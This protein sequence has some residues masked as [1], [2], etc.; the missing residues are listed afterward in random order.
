MNRSAK[1]RNINNSA[2]IMKE[3]YDFSQALK[4]TSTRNSNNNTALRKDISPSSF[5]KRIP[6]A[7]DTSVEVGTVRFHGNLDL[8]NNMVIDNLIR[9]NLFLKETI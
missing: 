1:F 2:Q 6:S 4:T 5:E 3:Q 7:S 9:D 8:N